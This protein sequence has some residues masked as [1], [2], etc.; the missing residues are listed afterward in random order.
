MHIL[1][2]MTYDYSFKLW[3]ET[4]NLEREALYFNEFINKTNFKITFLTFGDESEINYQ[5]INPNIKIIPIY[6]YIKF[7]SNKYIRFLKSIFIPIFLKK[8]LVNLNIDIVKQ[9]QLQGAWIALLIKLQL[10]KPLI[11]RTGYDVYSFKK[12]ERKNKL[13][14]IF[15]FLLTKITLN[16]S[17]IYTTTSVIDSFKLKKII[18]NNNKIRVRSNFVI[19]PDKIMEFANR[20]NNFILSVGRLEKQ[21]NLD[22]LL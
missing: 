15:Y 7:S 1:Y 4:G 21:K 2:L 5:K 16:Y 11:I 3:E 10:K 14:I 17:D 8:T 18:K 9:N 6:K 12:K 13:I 22:Y 20:P 19:S